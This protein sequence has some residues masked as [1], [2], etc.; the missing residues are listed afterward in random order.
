M[1]PNL[2]KKEW[3]EIDDITGIYTVPR[4]SVYYRIHND[5]F[6]KPVKVG[7]RSSRWLR[8]EVEAWFQNKLA[9]RDAQMSTQLVEI[10]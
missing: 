6:P 10:K 1:E 5:G 9:Q 2:R 4:S 8:S 3:L 7:K